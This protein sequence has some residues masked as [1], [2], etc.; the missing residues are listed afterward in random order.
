MFAAK[1]KK[2]N[3]CILQNGPVDLSCF[4]RFHHKSCHI[5]NTKVHK[6]YKVYSYLIMIPFFIESVYF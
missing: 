4:N 2:R 6:V 5:Y 1:K 3:A